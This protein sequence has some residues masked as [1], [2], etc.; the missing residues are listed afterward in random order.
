MY[1]SKCGKEIK[2]GNTFCT[3]CGEPIVTDKQNNAKKTINI[4]FTHL[5]IFIIAIALI[6]GILL[7]ISLNKGK[8]I[9]QYKDS[10][11]LT[12]KS[13]N[14]ETN[15]SEK[16]YI[17]LD[18]NVSLTG[19]EFIGEF[20]ENLT[21]IYQDMTKGNASLL[22]KYY[23]TSIENMKQLS[24]ENSLRDYKY[25]EIVFYY[26][27]TNNKIIGA[28]QAINDIQFYEQ[29]TNSQNTNTNEVLEKFMTAATNIFLDAHNDNSSQEFLDR[30][31]KYNDYL[32]KN[33]YNVGNTD[34][35]YYNNKFTYRVI[36]DIICVVTTDKFDTNKIEVLLF[37]HN[38]NNKPEDEIK[39]WYDTVTVIDENVSDNTTENF[40]DEIKRKYPNES[41]EICT[42]GDEYWLLDTAGK[43]IYFYDLESF[44]KALGNN[45]INETSKNNKNNTNIQSSN[46]TQNENELDPYTRHLI[47]FEEGFAIENYTETLDNWGI[48]YKVTKVQDLNF[49]DNVVT[50]IEPNNCYIDKNTIVTFSVSDNT[51]DM[52]VVVDTQYLVGL[53]NITGKYSGDNIQ[54]TL[55]ING[56]TIYNG[57]TEILGMVHA[58]SLGNISGKLTGTYN[59]EAT[60]DGITITK[61]IN[62]NI[63]CNSYT[64]RFEIYAGGDIGGG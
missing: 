34:F 11:E 18:S 62:Y 10:D 22:K 36:G 46:K 6:I 57:T 28:K 21:N 1:C 61:K 45:S 13:T 23:D 49:D 38:E 37:A 32:Q 55:K 20:S 63:R 2:E 27:E 16:V 17:T 56:Q 58:L 53:A 3:N 50:K 9:Q 5:I 35:E 4:K 54:L 26:N 25:T 12:S 41:E 8:T 42:N 48:K 24:I 60:V 7:V 30:Y 15:N 39:L 31:N 59:V 44:E 33:F 19:K 52:S 29:I 64:Q 51:Y 43:K 47:A 14:I 40:I